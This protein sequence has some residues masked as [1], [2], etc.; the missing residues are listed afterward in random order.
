MERKV[1]N[2][3]IAFLRSL[4]QM[5]S[6]NADWAEKAVRD[7]ATLTAEEAL[8]E[9]VIEVVARDVQDLLVQADG[10]TVA[11][12]VG[13]RRLATKDASIMV[14]EPTFRIR[15]LSALADPNIAFI[16]LI[17]GVYGI[18]FEMYTPGF[19]GP[20]AVGGI[21]LLLALAALSVLPVSYAGL[22]L[23][24]F[25]IALMIA[26]A[27]TPGIGVLGIGGAVAF[28]AGALFLFDPA[29]ADFTIRV[30][31]PLIAGA[32]LASTLLSVFAFGLA[33]KARK[34]K[35]A[36]GAEE[37]IGSTGQVIEWANGVGTVRAHG[38]V[39]AAR[40]PSSLSAGQHVRVAVRDGLTLVVEA[41]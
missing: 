10:R 24:L 28:V 11:T 16:L 2:D 9:R 39:W 18:L 14:L 23:L 12:A 25:G 31:W 21:C 8:R 35:V 26:E 30:A 36:T 40:G 19:V 37:M 17:V 41:V 38:E 33:I 7:A 20:G 4:A 5:R 34:R 13:T 27:F 15:F 32:A 29:G 6:R 1:M 3:A 22:G